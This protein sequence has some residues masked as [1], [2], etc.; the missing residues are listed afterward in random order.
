M[1]IAMEWAG[2]LMGNPQADFSIDP[3]SFS[4][5]DKIKKIKKKKN[6]L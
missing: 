2:K 4:D 6:C 5:C 3:L 1:V